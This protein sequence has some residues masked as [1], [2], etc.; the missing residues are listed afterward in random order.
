[1]GFSSKQCTECGKSIL[2]GHVTTVVNQ[3]MT[4]MVAITPDRGLVTGAYDGYCG[5][6]GD[7]EEIDNDSFF[8]ATV[9]HEA[10][11]IVAGRPSGYLGEG[12]WAEDQGYFFNGADYEI[13]RPAIA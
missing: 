8:E 9:Y 7:D 6:V 13:A 2:S 10:C 5:I 1:M 12:D 11:W 4:S 3:W